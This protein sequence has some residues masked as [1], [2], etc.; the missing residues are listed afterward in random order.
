MI[1]ELYEK[2]YND[3]NCSYRYGGKKLSLNDLAHFVA[4]KGDKYAT[5]TIRLFVIGRATNGW[6][7]LDCKSA[8][9]FG[10]DAEKQFNEPG[11]T[12]IA[13]DSNS[14]HN[15]PED[16]E[17]KIYYLSKS[18]FWRV[19]E[20]IWRGLT[21]SSD[22]RYIEHIAWSN[23]YKIAPDGANPT[24]YMCS[25]QLSACK[26][27]LEA[28]IHAYNP[29]HIL[30]IS[31]YNWYACEGYDFSTIFSNNEYHGSYT[32]DSKIYVEGKATYQ[33]NNISIPVVIT[34]RPEGKNESNFV[35]EVLKAF[36]E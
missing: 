10:E 1:K 23:L 9:L 29:T 34:C 15:I 21:G 5:D 35:T 7:G 32:K 17:S 2:L 31:G 14:L 24:N 8:L 22:F 19:I 18:S 6:E 36:Q 27:I 28:E 20:K 4:M 11:F 30:I 26:E 3:S 25:K 16:N 12:W 33:F 13:N